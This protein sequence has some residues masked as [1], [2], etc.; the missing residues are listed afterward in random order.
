MIQELVDQELLN[1]EL[2][3]EDLDTVVHKLVDVVNVSVVT[4]PVGENI[5]TIFS[6]IL[7]SSTDVTTVAGTWVDGKLHPWP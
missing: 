4:P 2:S 3:A 6:K 7:L 1:E 5:V